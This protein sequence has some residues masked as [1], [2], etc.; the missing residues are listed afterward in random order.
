MKILNATQIRELDAYTI[1]RETIASID[2][3]E[4]AAETFCSWF[5]EQFPD[6]NVPVHIFCGPGNNG[7]DGLA[8][9]RMLHYAFYEVKLYI[10]HLSPNKSADFQKN[11]EQLPKFEAISL[12]DISEGSVLPPLPPQ[13]IIIDALLGTGASR[14]IEG[15]WAVFINNLSQYS[16]IKI[17]IDLPSGLQAD[18]NTTGTT[19]CADY[20]F[21]FELPK[22]AFMLP[23]N[24]SRVGEW[25]FASI[26]LD[27]NFIQNAETPFHYL[28]LNDLGG[29]LKLR[30]RH[31]HKGQFGHA[32]L[33]A[34]S[35]GM[36]GAALLSGRA[37]LRSGTG[38]LTIHTPSCGYSI[39]QM[40]LPE[41][42]VS[43]DRHQFNF[44]E[45][46]EMSKYTAIGIGCG[47]GTKDFSI[48]GLDELLGAIGQKPLVLDADAL[49]IIAQ[50]NWQNRI[51]RGAII[52]P[53]PKEFTRLFGTA[54]DDFA[55]LELLRA[56]AIKYGL[57]IIR[58]GAN[59][60]IALPDGQVWFNSS[61][62]PGMATGGSGDVLTGVLTGLLA[63][64][65]TAEQACK[66]GVFLHGLAG[67]LAAESLGHEALLASDIVDHLG[68]AF[69]LLK[70]S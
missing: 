6:Q 10:C 70:K 4:R 28:T 20:T 37:A 29:V 9:A 44:S 16:G 49:N 55:G 57:Y 36:M 34:G 2:L 47:L 14:P 53:H 68:K 45:L 1:A 27:K 67:D 54:P 48:R 35:Q 64:G 65:Y 19:F 42:M 56:S 8:V 40:G 30:M 63:Q 7:G 23:E 60:A 24:E 5:V 18:K 59:T 46:P 15:Y 41:A 33:I 31:A 17:A 66:L 11:I 52:S 58:K 61:G 12:Q 43:S 50:Q 38:L 22:L 26:G 25:T 21:S 39:L 51:P 62:N 3:M 32:L 69:Q 13:G